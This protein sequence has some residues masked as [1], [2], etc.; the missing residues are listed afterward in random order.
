MSGALSIYLTSPLSPFPNNRFSYLIMS[1][2]SNEVIEKG[3][4]N[5]KTARK[6][7][8]KKKDTDRS[9]DVGGNRD[10]NTNNNIKHQKN[11]AQLDL[12]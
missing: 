3:G 8:T 6:R 2:L 9:D 5:R 1:S 12:M 7:N 10:L 11:Q 4:N